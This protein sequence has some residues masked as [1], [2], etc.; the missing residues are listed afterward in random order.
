VLCCSRAL[1]AVFQDFL[2]VSTALALS[3]LLRAAPSL[4]LWFPCILP[5]MSL[6]IAPSLGPSC[7]S[8]KRSPA[9]GLSP[10]RYTVISAKPQERC[11]KNRLTDWSIVSMVPRARSGPRR[12][13]KPLPGCGSAHR[14]LMQSAHQ[15]VVAS[16]ISGSQKGLH[17]YAKHVIGV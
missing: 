11:T 10:R 8:K 9:I 14:N 15:Y 13:L 17:G 16:I 3:L 7:G 5:Q 6:A 12:C 4:S 2:R 1:Y